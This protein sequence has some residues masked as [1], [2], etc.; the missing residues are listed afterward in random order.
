MCVRRDDRPDALDGQIIG[1]EPTADGVWRILFY[2]FPIASFDERDAL[3][4]APGGTKTCPK[5]TG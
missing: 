4:S 1:F 5:A 3:L 2:A